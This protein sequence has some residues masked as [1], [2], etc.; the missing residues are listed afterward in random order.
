[1]PGTRRV[2]L[3]P[4]PQRPAIVH[5]Y[6]T[7]TET[8]D[9]AQVT[10]KLAYQDGEYVGVATGDADITARPRLVGEATLRAVEEVTENRVRLNLEAVA[11][12]SL[13]T[14]QVAMAQV[15]IDGDTETLVG[16]ALLSEADRSAATVRAVLDAINRRLETV[17]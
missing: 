15:K 8:A 9:E 12:T 7:D 3:P 11:T 16:T 13:G 1:M 5:I 10:I 4:M 2:S 14:S 6:E 17:L